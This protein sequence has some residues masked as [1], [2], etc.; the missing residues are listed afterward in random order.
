MGE[1]GTPKPPLISLANPN[2]ED[3]LLV[4]WWWDEDPISRPELCYIQDLFTA[5]CVCETRVHFSVWLLVDARTLSSRCEL[6]KRPSLGLGCAAKAIHQ[7]ER[8]SRAVSKHKKSHCCSSLLCQNAKDKPGMVFQ[9][10][11]LA[12]V[13]NCACKVP[14]VSFSATWTSQSN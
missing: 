1:I 10:W 12:L 8:F 11:G 6:R 7:I 5:N 3:C 9:C 4:A 2:F 14:R 13:A